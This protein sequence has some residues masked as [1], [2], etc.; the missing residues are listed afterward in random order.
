MTGRKERAMMKRWT[1]SYYN[2]VDAEFGFDCGDVI[3]MVVEDRAVAKSIAR[4]MN[5][6]APDF[7]SYFADEETE[8]EGQI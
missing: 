1:V 4:H 3:Y 6:T 7:I 5:K 8:G 2:Q